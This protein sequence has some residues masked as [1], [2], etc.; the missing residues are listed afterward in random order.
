M[1]LKQ[2]IRF[3]TAPDG[4]RIAYATSG[5]G[6]PL[7]KVGNWLSHLEF[8][9]TS[10]VWGHV[11]EMLSS[12][13]T[14]V[15]YDQRGTGLSDREVEQVSFEVWLQDLETV[16]D[17]AGLER[18]PMLAISQGV[19]LAIAYTARHPERVSRL[20]LQG[21]YARGR[22]KRGGGRVL[23]EEA[24]TQAKLMEIGWG[25]ADAAFR[26][27]FTS[28]FLPEGTPEQ[29]Q[30]FNELAR[31]STSPSNAA[32]T[33][34]AFD[35]IDV[36]DLLPQVHCPTLVLHA[37]GDLRVPFDEG[38]LIAGAITQA[39]FVPLH[40]VHH[41]ML[42]QDEVWPLWV[43]EVR[44]FLGTV[45]AGAQDPALARLTARERE[46]LELIAQGRDNTQAAAALQLSEKTVRNHITSIFA[47]LEVE[48]RPQAIVLAR[49]AGLGRG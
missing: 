29:H 30:W 40:S 24:E 21:G 32:R 42:A 8:D 4:V 10:P 2:Q 38:R 14:L 47:K 45:D 34:R 19:S 35:S 46:V 23:D 25:R 22:R 28:Q 3:C 20:V 39:R 26:Q 48:N 15:R 17:A 18:F 37:T 49:N 5:R 27:F 41:L 7:L 6:P 44:D 12:R 11:L 9:L 13:N 16:I 36:S 31:V 1:P 43:E 33:L